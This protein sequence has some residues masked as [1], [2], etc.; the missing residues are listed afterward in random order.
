M[1]LYCH[2]PIRLEGCLSTGRFFMYFTE[3]FEALPYRF[4]LGFYS[5][6]VPSNRCIGII[7]ASEV[8]GLLDTVYLGMRGLWRL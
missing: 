1:S 6:Q 4:K 2:I 8:S 5:G 7:S 3:S